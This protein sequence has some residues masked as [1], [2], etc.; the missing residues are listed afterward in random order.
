M[1]QS[2]AQDGVRCDDTWG[3]Q[4]PSEL[5]SAVQWGLWLPRCGVIIIGVRPAHAVKDHRDEFWRVPER[6][7]T[8]REVLWHTWAFQL[9]VCRGSHKACSDRLST[10]RKAAFAALKWKLWVESGSK[11]G[12][13][14]ARRWPAAVFRRMLRAAASAKSIHA[15]RDWAG[16]D[17]EAIMPWS[18]FSLFLKSRCASS[19]L[20]SI[21]QNAYT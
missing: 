7:M 3:F 14:D 18:F 12:Q 5:F 8:S 19:H 21:R 11:S 6:G 20:G 13:G 16:P 15:G 1:Q 9:R 17:C 4:K 10:T 2:W